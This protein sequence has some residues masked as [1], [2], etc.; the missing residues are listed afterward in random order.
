VLE[1][2]KT[3]NRAYNQH[4]VPLLIKLGESLQVV[5]LE[6][7]LQSIAGLSTSVWSMACTVLEKTVCILR[8][9]IS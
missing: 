6:S 4:G 1:K 8:L 5:L 3:K 9:P 2:Q 7:F